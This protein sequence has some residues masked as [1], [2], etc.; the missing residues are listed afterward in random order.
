MGLV[1]NQ[2]RAVID[3]NLQNARVLTELSLRIASE[4]GDGP[5]L[6]ISFDVKFAWFIVGRSL[7]GGTK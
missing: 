4:D 3:R 7:V 6:A 1:R 5:T 2:H